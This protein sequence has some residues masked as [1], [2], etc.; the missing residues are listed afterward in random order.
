MNTAD[1]IAAALLA[2]IL[3]GIIAA[4]GIATAANLAAQ[5][6]QLLARCQARDSAASCRLQLFGR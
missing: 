6:A 4:A 2:G 1:R 5:D 3:P